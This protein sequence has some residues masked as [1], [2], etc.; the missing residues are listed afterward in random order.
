MP[1]V[2]TTTDLY[3]ERSVYVADSL[4]T[5]RTVAGPVATSATLTPSTG[6]YPL[7]VLIGSSA[8]FDAAI[9]WFAWNPTS[10]AA[11]DGSTILQP[12]IAGT[13]LATGRW[14]A[15]A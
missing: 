4:T 3:I 13:A 12:T 5:A 8:A 9:K 7:L 14:Q 1:N 15:H 2:N 6:P 10:V 11:D